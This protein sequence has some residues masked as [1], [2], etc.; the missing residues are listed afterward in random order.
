MGDHTDYNGGF[1][2][3]ATIPQHPTVEAAPR[4]GTRVRVWSDQFPETVEY[5]LGERV[6]QGTWTDY[7]QGVTI[8]LEAYGLK[9]GF[10]ARIASTVPPGS[11]L[12]SSASLEMSIGRAVRELFSL[13]IDDVELA[14]AGQRAENLFVGAPVGIMDQMA[15]SLGDASAAL[16]LDTQSLEFERVAIPP[17]VSLVV[18][19]SGITHRHAV[20]GY[21]T[22]RRECQE[23]ADA[24]GV[25]SLRE[26]SEAHAAA[27]EKLP[28][29]L[30]R[31]V[32]H[33]LS[34]NRRVRETVDAFRAGNLAEAGRLFLESHASLRDDFEV[35]VPEVDAL[36]ELAMRAPGTYGARLTG[37]G[38]GGSIVALA[39]DSQ[40]REAARTTVEG[41]ARQ[42]GKTA[43]VM[44]P[45]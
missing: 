5:A 34:E 37:G 30:D 1:V 21:V 33:V 39:E 25:Q 19:H 24:L 44:L 35:S 14:K 38:F 40:A 10:D 45:E 7:V 6:P 31:R 2:L 3:P 42:T 22:R 26:L 28:A 8:E 12:S 27:I 13:R 16:F 11:G 41:Y 17:G 9:E 32:R 15:C 43:R 36:V 4:G 23:A 18:I 29:P 20:G